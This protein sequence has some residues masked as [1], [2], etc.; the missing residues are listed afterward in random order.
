MFPV[1]HRK[2]ESCGFENILSA[3]PG[4]ESPADESHGCSRI[5]VIQFAHGVYQDERSFDVFQ[6]F[7]KLGMT[8]EF[9]TVFQDETF[10]FLTTVHMPWGKGDIEIRH[11]LFQ[12]Q[13]G[14]H[15]GAF[16]AGPGRSKNHP[17]IF[18]GRCFL[19][20]Q[21]IARTS[22]KFYIARYPDSLGRN[23]QC[24]YPVRI[25]LRAHG[26]NRD[27]VCDP[28]EEG[29]DFPVPIRRPLRHPAVD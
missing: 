1:N 21:R 20:G 17:G 2:T 15:D 3:K 25:R 22:V 4:I 7:G 6:S 5:V 8:F 12:A 23:P 29:Q 27:C 16:I 13:D 26:E 28:A 18:R 19:S 11:F 24:Q 9:H 10:D 14:F